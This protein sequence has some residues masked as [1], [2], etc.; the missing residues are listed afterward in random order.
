VFFD[1]LIFSAGDI[2]KWVEVRIV[3]DPGMYLVWPGIALLLCYPIAIVVR[4]YTRK[5]DT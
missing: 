1:K 2:R 3:R 4:R 5:A